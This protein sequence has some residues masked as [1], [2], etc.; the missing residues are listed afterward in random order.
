MRFAQIFRHSKDPRKS[1]VSVP[2]GSAPAA[3][4]ERQTTT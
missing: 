4:D 2:V 3:A 1:C